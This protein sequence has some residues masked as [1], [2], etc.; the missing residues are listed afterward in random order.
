MKR[1]FTKNLCRFAPG[2]ALA[3]CVLTA[4]WLV[5]SHLSA[6]LEVA[7]VRDDR[8]PAMTVDRTEHDFGNV[9]DTSSVS[10]EFTVTN[11]GGRRL[12]LSQR[13]RSC[14]CVFGRPPE[15]VIPPGASRPLV[16]VLETDEIRGPVALTL[17]YWTNDPKHP[18][19]DLVLLADVKHPRSPDS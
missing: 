19:L 5:G 17:R 13:S 3:A 11:R 1:S 15:I 10:V 2:A 6:R 14:E 12:I 18:N 16:A 7:T 8:P 4:T 9:E